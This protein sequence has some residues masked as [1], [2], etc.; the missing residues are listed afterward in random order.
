MSNR[1]N[2]FNELENRCLEF[3]LNVKSFC[4]DVKQDMIHQDYIL[5]VIRSSAAIGSNIIEANE[6]LGEDNL[7]HKMKIARKESKETIYWL[8]HFDETEERDFLLDEVDQLRKILSSIIS[9]LSL[10]AQA[11][12]YTN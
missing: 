6:K 7:I 4:S 1:V 12:N 2:S 10:N 9:K 11:N 5:Q 8:H 3:S